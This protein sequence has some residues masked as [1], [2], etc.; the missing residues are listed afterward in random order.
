MVN[1]R[2]SR[3]HSAISCVGDLVHPAS[4]LTEWASLV[5]GTKMAGEC[6][7]VAA[8]RRSWSRSLGET[9]IGEVSDDQVEPTITYLWAGRLKHHLPSYIP[10]LPVA[11]I[12]CRPRPL[13]LSST[14]MV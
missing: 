7:D 2:E 13:S 12:A 6:T 5:Y 11:V 10:S 9:G 3:T 14:V 8:S 4:A 1:E